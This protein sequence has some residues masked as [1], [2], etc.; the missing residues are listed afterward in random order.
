MN[1]RQKSILKLIGQFL[2]KYPEQRFG[3]ALCN[4]GINEFADKTNP[5]AKKHLLRNIYNDSDND[6]LQRTKQAKMT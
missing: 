6:I 4:L 3:Q 5:S 1:K 2:E